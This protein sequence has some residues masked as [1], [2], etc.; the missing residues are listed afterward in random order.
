MKRLSDRAVWDAAYRQMDT[1]EID[2]CSA[3]VARLV[4]A[5]SDADLRRELD[6]AIGE[7]VAT[8][9]DQAFAAGWKCARRPELLVFGE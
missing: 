5:V 1:A 6:D 2:R 7:Y 3:N 9:F 8:Y 4:G